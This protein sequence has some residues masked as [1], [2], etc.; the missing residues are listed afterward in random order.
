MRRPRVL[1]LSM[2][3]AL[4]IA[5]MAIGLW[6]DTRSGSVAPRAPIPASALAAFQP[7]KPITNPTQAF[8]AAQFYLGT[9]RLRAA[10]EIL[11]YSAELCALHV[12]PLPAP[13][14]RVRLWIPYAVR[15]DDVWLVLLEGH[16]LSSPLFQTHTQRAPTRLRVCHPG[17]Q[18]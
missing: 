1:L 9:T 10:G 6:L 13:Q 3:S 4:L 12:K 16:G 18:H 2:I 11:P 7:G 15:H 8:V 14:N 17:C 5:I